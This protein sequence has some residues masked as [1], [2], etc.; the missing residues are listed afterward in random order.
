M[1]RWFQLGIALTLVL[2]T[3]WT[4]LLIGLFFYDY[5]LILTANLELSMLPKVSLAPG[6]AAASGFILLFLLSASLA[7]QIMALHRPHRIAS[8]VTVIIEVSKATAFNF[9][10]N[11]FL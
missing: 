8:L 10:R 2:N 6:A 9:S 4:M 11:L 1:K 5:Y 7:V 3:L